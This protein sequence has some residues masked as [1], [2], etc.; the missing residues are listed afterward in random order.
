MKSMTSN[1][2]LLPANEDND[3]DDTIPD[4]V[5]RSNLVPDD[6]DDD[7]DDEEDEILHK[8]MP[9]REDKETELLFFDSNQPSEDMLTDDDDLIFFDAVEADDN[10]E[11]V[12]LE[13]DINYCEEFLHT[14]PD[15]NPPLQR[16]TFKQKTSRFLCNLS[17]QTLTGQDRDFDTL[18][19]AR[20]VSR[21]ARTDN[22]ST[23]SIKDDILKNRLYTSMPSTSK[24]SADDSALDDATVQTSN[25]TKPTTGETGEPSDNP[26]SSTGDQTLL[27]DM[28]PPPTPETDES[29]TTDNHET[30]PFDLDMATSQELG[31][32]DPVKHKLV[33]ATHDTRNPEILR[34]Y[35]AYFPLRIV[36]ETLARTTQLAKTVGSYPL[37]RHVKSRF[38]WL[39]KFRLNEKVSTDT[40]FANCRALK[41]ETCAQVFYGMT[42]HVINVYGMK[43]ESEFATSAYPDF[44]RHEGAPSILRRDRGLAQRSQKVNDINRSLLIGDEFSE[45][46]HQQQNPVE[47]NA[48]RW[49]K[50]HTKVILDRTNAPPELWLDVMEYLA[51]VHNH[52][53]KET[54]R[55]AIPMTLR[56]GETRDISHLLMYTF[57]EP[58]YYHDYDT[59]PDS[60]EKLGYWIGTAH[61]IGDAL[62][63]KILTHDTQEVIY[64]STVRPANVKNPNYRAGVPL[65][66]L[67]PKPQRLQLPGQF[68]LQFTSAPGLL[69]SSKQHVTPPVSHT[70][71][72]PQPPEKGRS[73][74]CETRNNKPQLR[75]SPRL[76]A[77]N[78]CS[79]ASNNYFM[80]HEFVDTQ[81]KQVDLQKAEAL[82]DEL[83]RRRTT[84]GSQVNLN[85]LNKKELEHFRY[86]KTCEVF[87]DT[88]DGEL[89]T[90][91]PVTIL[92]KIVRRS[93]PGD[94]H[95]RVKVLWL[96]GT[97]SWVRLSEFQLDHPDLVA[98]Y[99]KKNE[100]EHMDEMKWTS[101]YNQIREEE[102]NRPMHE[103]EAA[104]AIFAM[105][106]DP[107]GKYK[108][109][110]EVPRSIRHAY[111]LD[112]ING[113]D[114]WKQAIAKELK[115]INDHCTFRN[116]TSED[117]LSTYQYIPYH[118]VFDVKF[119]GRRK[120]RLVCGGNHTEIEKEDVYSGVV[121]LDTVRL[122]FQIAQMR[123][124]Q[125]CA[126]DVGTAF[127]YGK[128]KE[129][130]Y[131]RAGKEFG[132]NAGKIL[133]ISKGLY[134]L[135]SSAARFHEHLANEVR[136]LGF[137]PSK[138]DPDLYIREV[139]GSHYE[140]IAIYV[141]DLL[142]FSKNSMAI[143]E[144]LQKVYT[145][146]GV[147]EPV[148][149]LGGNVEKPINDH[150]ER[151]G[152]T[153]ALSAST[154]IK[155]SIERFEKLFDQQF[156]TR[157]LPMQE[158]DH[159]E[160]D[161]SP[162]CNPDMASKYRSLLGSANWI[163]TL[164]RFDI[165]YAVQS[166][167]R[168]G[169]IPRE[170]H[171]KRMINLFG[172]LKTRPDGKIICDP[173]YPDHTKHMMNTKVD[174][175]D[176]YPDAEEELPPDMPVPYGPKARITCYVDSDHAHC[177]VTRRSTTGI[178]LF[179][180]NMP[181]RWVSKRQKTVE[182]S[183]YGSELIAARIA[184]DLIIEM[185]YSLRMLGIPVEKTS[186]MLGDN[187]SV[188]LNTTIP[189]S[190]LK[191][192]H[193]AIAYH[194]VREAVAAGIVHFAHI[195][196]KENLADMLT[197]S[198]NKATFYDLT[199]KCLFRV[200]EILKRG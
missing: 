137:R 143:I 30:L 37:V 116:P 25:T 190:I 47:K 35:L 33:H 11:P 22:Y 163:I 77:Q 81:E 66:A 52:T 20:Y 179:V 196:S 187:L 38:A 177:R 104:R 169:M 42:S 157:T 69:S 199:R 133:I 43:R 151:M 27:P 192:K 99:A 60:S 105:Q 18:S 71:E 95:I 149:Y 128:T 122:A 113:D 183:T 28:T 142:V 17:Y 70:G 14:S 184:T 174:W 180:N 191:K 6:D 45:P 2:H 63:F 53:S 167:A 58:V 74:S 80:S 181:V 61:N 170:G 48:I 115:E 195:D 147:G 106:Y 15:Q 138:M 155:N 24:D 129:K 13:L 4:L 165:A 131:I 182:S 21:V 55:W 94:T 82:M 159:P 73:K 62:T 119:D 108:F 118:F 197:K 49:L 79:L 194:R 111:Y 154:Y 109:G 125:V 44:L 162:I 166:L 173:Q 102:K 89:S 84:T 23:S 114:L 140:M 12:K 148:Y 150:W 100:L 135:R 189:S 8:D 1:I 83:E 188:V 50:I 132:A 39:N 121:G 68:D 51:D 32:S 78:N 153:T 7:D 124:L 56:H 175:S 85:T 120:A 90:W 9:A 41:G 64:R 185:R 98:D 5:P 76:R 200:P 59:Y 92:D 112:Q 3:D 172:Y 103:Q 67:P 145:L 46:H 164:G 193:N 110:V 26:P 171:V 54:L 57:Y 134:G 126:A 136:K 117:D 72:H 34:R 144:E 36:K 16:L 198:V 160:L 86:V 65:S 107:Q 186:L 93:T 88:D 19:Y 141:D 168:F 10:I 91:T 31:V 161:D 152:I 146:K 29:N 178:L 75:R 130:V 40:V 123:G 139:K 156:P 87:S 176:F 127:L 158:K 101:T 96:D 97:I